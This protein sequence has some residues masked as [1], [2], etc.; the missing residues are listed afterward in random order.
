MDSQ[1]SKRKKKKVCLSGTAHLDNQINV[2]SSVCSRHLCQNAKDRHWMNS[3]CCR[4]VAVAVL[5][6]GINMVLQ[7]DSCGR[8]LSSPSSRRSAPSPSPS[9]SPS[10]D[11]GTA[12]LAPENSH[13]DGRQRGLFSEET[14]RAVSDS[15]PLHFNL[16]IVQ[17]LGGKHP[18]C[19]CVCVCER[20]PWAD[21]LKAQDAMQIRRPL[22]K[23]TR[24][25]AGLRVE[26]RRNDELINQRPTDGGKHR[27]EL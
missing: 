5:P 6:T 27:D 16:F 26:V 18:R 3:L 9:P 20:R 19:V 23:S 17:R 12:A 24:G 25:T 10:A 22:C 21:R 4:Q 14:A 2:S 11:S 1:N 13:H 8:D 15:S 7:F